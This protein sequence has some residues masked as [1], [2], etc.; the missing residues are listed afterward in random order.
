VSVEFGAVH[1]QLEGCLQVVEEAVDVGE[2]DGDI[3]AGGEE[4]GDLDGGDE[5]AAMR[6][7]R[8]CGT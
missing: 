8:R 4:L 5:V 6:A 3:A 2:E 1:D 7:A